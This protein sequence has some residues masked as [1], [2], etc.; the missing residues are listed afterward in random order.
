MKEI[1]KKHD[2]VCLQITKKPEAE[3][4]YQQNT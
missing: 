2:Y 3:E 1:H 4:N